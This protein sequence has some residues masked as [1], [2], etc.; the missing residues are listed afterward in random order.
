MH[1]V[2]AFV[3]NPHAKQAGT[4]KETGYKLMKEEME[5]TVEELKDYLARNPDAIVTATLN[6]KSNERDKDKTDNT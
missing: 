4:I 5:M 2:K 3:P 1:A 6:G